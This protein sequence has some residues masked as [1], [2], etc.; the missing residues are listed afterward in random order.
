MWCRFFANIVPA[1]D[2]LTSLPALPPRLWTRKTGSPL[3]LPPYGEQSINRTV[4]RYC[5]AP[6]PHGQ[7]DLARPLFQLQGMLTLLLSSHLSHFCYTMVVA[8]QARA[9]PEDFCY[10]TSRNT[11]SCATIFLQHSSPLIYKS[12]FLFYFGIKDVYQ[13]TTSVC[14]S[15]DLAQR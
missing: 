13:K 7:V 14:I 10:H 11:R 12:F 9:S 8:N 4:S 3:L 5:G 6:W 1:S 2:Q 15:V